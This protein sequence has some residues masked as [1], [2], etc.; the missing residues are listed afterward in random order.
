MKRTKKIII[1][2]AIK[3]LSENSNATLDEIA[4]KAEVNKRTLH[5]YFDGKKDLVVQV[6]EELGNTYFEDIIEILSKEQSTI[7]TFKELFRYDVEVFQNYKTIHNLYEKHRSDFLFET[8]IMKKI[9]GEFALVYQS[10]KDEG[11][12]NAEFSIEWI[13]V[14]HFGLLESGYRFNNNYKDTEECF[15]KLWKLFWCGAS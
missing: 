4:Q 5:R 14:Y 2:S 12:L 10:L 9:N 3:A 8:N 1:D 6:F 13:Q 11:F 7:V 15:Q